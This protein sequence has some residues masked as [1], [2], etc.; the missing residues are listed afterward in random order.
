MSK[1]TKHHFH[2]ERVSTCKM[3]HRAVTNLLLLLLPLMDA[4]AHADSDDAE[5]FDIA[6]PCPDLVCYHV[7][8]LRSRRTQE[9][10][11]IVHNG[12]IKEAERS[13][14]DAQC[15]VPVQRGTEDHDGTH[16]CKR[17]DEVFTPQKSVPE[18]SVFPGQVWSF[19]CLLLAS[20]GQGVC[21]TARG[22]PVHLSWVDQAGVAVQEDSEHSIRYQSSCHV[23]LTLTFQGPAR[24]TLKCRAQVGDRVWT[25]EELQ[26]QVAAPRGKGRGGFGVDVEEPQAS[27]RYQVGVVVGVLACAA[28]AALAAM[29]VIAKRR[30]TADAVEATSA[31][32]PSHHVEDDAVYADVVYADVVYADVVLPAGAREVS[33][34]R[35]HATEYA[36]LR[37]Q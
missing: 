31:S 21:H 33:F 30:K 36:C 27:V 5:T 1:D 34:C 12:R 7:W 11:V 35:G 25:S 23:T 28:L 2:S 13:N 17:P 3:L 14:Q 37:H 9:D 16:Y 10:I 32:C 4:G 15:S 22:R 26:V 24:E 20:S 29:F 8:S 6:F 18:V 19:H